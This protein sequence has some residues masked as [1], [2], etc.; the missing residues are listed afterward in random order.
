MPV[1]DMEEGVWYQCQRCTHCCQWP[2]EVVLS[3]TDIEKIAEF[4]DLNVY[5]FVA[6]Y[7]DLRGNRT[8]LT[9]REKKGAGTTCIFLEGTE[10]LINPVKP[11][12]CAGFPN[13]WNF[14]GWRK[15]CEALAVKTEKGALDEPTHLSK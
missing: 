8:G 11:G 9:L 7:T 14:R 4:L 3:D 5:D 1:Y 13:E 6:H 2:G 12:Q 15:H 10:C